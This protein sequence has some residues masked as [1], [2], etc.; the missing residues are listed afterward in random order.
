MLREP[1]GVA[2]GAEAAETEDTG[3]MHQ[4]L[5]DMILMIHALF[6]AFVIFGLVLIVIGVA[7]RWQWIRNPRFR[8]AHLIAIGIVVVQAWLGSTCPLTL[9]ENSARQAGSGIGYTGSFIQHW[10]HQII[11]Y[12]FE[13]WLFTLAYTLFGILVVLAWILAPPTRKP[14]CR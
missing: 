7:Q 8:V 11:F 2:T 1:V 5:A 9:W 12:D 3:A 13:P 6:V 14:W 4:L 10:L